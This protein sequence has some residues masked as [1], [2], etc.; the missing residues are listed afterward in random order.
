MKKFF[1]NQRSGGFSIG[2]IGRY[3]IN[4]K[5]GI[6]LPK[7]I[8]YLTAHDFLGIIDGLV[9]LKYFDRLNDTGNFEFL[10]IYRGIWC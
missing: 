3:K 6:H 5:L 2:E 1:L 9:E 7:D 10:A 4:K 8:D